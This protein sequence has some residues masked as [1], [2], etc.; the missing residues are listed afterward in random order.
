MSCDREAPLSRWLALATRLRRRGARWSIPHRGAKRHSELLGNISAGLCIDGCGPGMLN[1]C[2]FVFCGSHGVERHQISAI[3]SEFV[4]KVHARGLLLEST[5]AIVARQCGLEFASI[6][7]GIDMPTA[8]VSIEPA[9][10]DAGLDAALEIGWKALDGAPTGI[11][12]L[13]ELGAANTT[14]AAILAEVLGCS[15]ALVGRGTGIDD[16]RFARK[17]EIVGR[18]VSRV[19]SSRAGGFE[20]LRQ[21]GGREIAALVGALL[22]CAEEQRTVVLDGYVT[23]VAALFTQVIVGW[24]ANV[25]CPCRTAELGQPVVCSRLGLNPFI[26]LNHSTGEGVGASVGYAF[27]SLSRGIIDRAGIQMV[28]PT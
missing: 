23:C 27:L 4:R 11:I 22:R 2:V 18:S 14:I 10:D 9:M 6:D 28:L 21:A 24:I 8:D 1:G 20:V 17:Q 5:G 25:Y 19:K 15:G 13:G 7:C 16:T 3:D 26:A 12:A